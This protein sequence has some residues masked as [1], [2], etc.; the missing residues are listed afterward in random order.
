DP[1]RYAPALSGCDP[2]LATT[3][4]GRVAGRTS[5]CATFEDRLY[6]FSS[7]ATLKQ[8]RQDPGRYTTSRVHSKK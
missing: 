2:V 8:F 6:M 7:Q 1:R 5:A 3:G 4:A